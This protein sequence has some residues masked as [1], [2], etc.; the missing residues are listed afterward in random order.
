MRISSKITTTHA[1]QL[2]SNIFQEHTHWKCVFSNAMKMHANDQTHKQIHWPCFQRVFLYLARSRA[3]PLLLTFQGN[4]PFVRS[5]SWTIEIH[6]NAC[7]VSGYFDDAPL[8][9]WLK[10]R[11]GFVESN[12]LSATYQCT[13]IA[14]DF[15]IFYD[16]MRSIKSCCKRY[17]LIAINLLRLSLTTQ[18]VTIVCV[19]SS[20]EWN[21]NMTN[22]SRIRSINPGTLWKCRISPQS[23][24]ESIKYRQTFYIYIDGT[25]EQ[26]KRSLDYTYPWNYL[27]TCV[28]SINPEF[29]V[30][31]GY[32]HTVSIVL[33]V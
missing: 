18:H 30:A 4:A 24:I 1:S 11:T 17:L 3:S 27:H 32:T 13:Y 6:S 7:D 22:A 28:L 10:E 20:C 5:T 19:P 23:T 14:F 33:F 16:L 9:R 29:S 31:E 8:P 15:K 25:A 26:C 2:L 21:V 12:V